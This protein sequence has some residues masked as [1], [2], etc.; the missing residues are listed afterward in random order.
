[1]SHKSL[2]LIIRVE[3]MGCGV[4]IIAERWPLCSFLAWQ[5]VMLL[6]I[7]NWDTCCIGVFG[8]SR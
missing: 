5:I 3:A 1:M 7:S 4:E 6:R 8:A 2:L